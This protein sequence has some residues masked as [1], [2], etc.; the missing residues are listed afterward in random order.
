MFDVYKGVN[1]ND[2]RFGLR[3]LLKEN[4]FKKSLFELGFVVYKLR[5]YQQAMKKAS[6]NISFP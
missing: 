6:F 3:L 2:E 5:P 1:M 4:H